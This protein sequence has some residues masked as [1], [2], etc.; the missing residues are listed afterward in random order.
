[1][2]LL[3]GRQ[4]QNQLFVLLH[5]VHSR[6]GK[7]SDQSSVFTPFSTGSVCKH[8]LLPLLPPSIKVSVG[9]LKSLIKVNPPPDLVN[10]LFHHYSGFHDAPKRNISYRAW[11]RQSTQSHSVFAW[12]T[13][14]WMDGNWDTANVELVCLIALTQLSQVFFFFFSF[15]LEDFSLL[16]WCVWTNRVQREM[17][18]SASQCLTRPRRELEIDRLP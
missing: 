10:L 7:E 6:G 9:W 2:S 17:W 18:T 14:G 15:G 4:W 12:N 3:A 8:I 13:D 11:R 5:T 1:M 16:F